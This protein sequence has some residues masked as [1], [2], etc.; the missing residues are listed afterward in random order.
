MLQSVLQFALD[1][2]VWLFG[3]FLVFGGIVAFAEITQRLE[4]KR[5]PPVAR[6]EET[7]ESDAP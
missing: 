7:D 2:R 5:K 1:P 4:K 3:G 6:T